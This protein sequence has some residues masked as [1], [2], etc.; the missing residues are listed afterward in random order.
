MEGGVKRWTVPMDFD[1]L[2]NQ[3]GGDHQSG[4]KS[5][6]REFPRGPSGSTEN[7]DRSFKG[8]A[9]ATGFL[10]A[11]CKKTSYVSGSSPW[12]RE[13]RDTSQARER[14][15]A[16]TPSRP[17]GR[18]R[19]RRREEREKERRRLRAKTKR[20]F[21]RVK[22]VEEKSSLDEDNYCGID[23]LFILSSADEDSLSLKAMAMLR[24]AIEDVGIKKKKMATLRRFGPTNKKIEKKF[25]ACSSQLTEFVLDDL[26]TYTLCELE[27]PFSIEQQSL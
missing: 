2:R 4:E 14:D 3:Y 9:P 22:E 27:I 18:R 21:F 16:P 15:A 23:E 6:L 19:R 24:E 12:E 17:A 8:N 1:W 13:G 5:I 10:V 20:Y 7:C 11:F 26:I 25:L